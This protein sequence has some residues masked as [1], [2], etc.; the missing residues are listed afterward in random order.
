[1]LGELVL[2][3][4]LHVKNLGIIEDI[5]WNPDSG[6]SVIT[7]ETGAGKS[8]IIDAVEL[9]LYGSISPE[10]IRHGCSS[11]QIEGVFNIAVPGRYAD[12][13]EFLNE[14]V[15]T[16]E[17]D[18]LIIS[19]E[20][21][22]GK[23]AQIRINNH[24]VTRTF[25][26]QVG[27]WLI[28]IHG[29]SQHLSLLDSTAHIEFLDDFC[30]LSALKSSY[31]AQIVNMRALENK[32]ASLRSSEQETLRQQD[33]LK[34]QIEEIRQAEL[35]EGEDAEL[36]REKRIISQAVRLKEQA[37]QIYQTLAQSDGTGYSP[38]VVA[39]LHQ[40]VQSLRKL[41]ELDPELKPQ[42]EYLEKA[43][44]GIDESARDIYAYAEKLDFDPHRLEEIENRL[45][46]IRNLKRKF[47]TSIEQIAAF[48]AKSQQELAMLDR[49]QERG[50]EL[51]DSLA[52]SRNAAGQMAGQ[53]SAARQAA[54]IDL[55]QRVKKELNDLEMGHMDF[56][57]GISWTPSPDG[58]P[59][60]DN[61][62]LAFSTKGIDQVEFL[63]STN[64][65]EPLLPLA[66]IASTG[67]L[68]RFTL[69][70]KSALAAADRIPVLIF[71][72]IDIGVGGRSGEI[73]GKKLWTL[74]R[75]H[76]VICVTHLP[77]IAAFADSHF[78]VRKQTTG[79][80]TVSSLESL[81]NNGRMKETAL[82]LAGPSYSTAAQNNA[83]E[84]LKKA[85]L[86]KDKAGHYE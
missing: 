69:A 18:S 12:L 17:D 55:A 65:G 70:L 80:R 53:L 24:T 77:Q 23:P 82:M 38:S 20:I 22:T 48:Q 3:Q 63:V 71:D 42:L 11:A 44:F 75:H 7:G 46:L 29:Q 67:E 52:A 16:A 19:C 36:E 45:E 34:Y 28:D 84:L 37:V 4:E 47:G 14:K 56:R 61:Q 73:V 27:R 25:L 13:R 51:K 68:S 78:L 9:L 74:S 30:G 43:Y 79:D 2:L 6:F 60:K 21:K 49:S 64:P 32:I 41:S 35:H 40:A 86:W 26:R 72:E 62:L 8:L 50:I 59:G 85:S 66:R 15:I 54:A 81:D 83:R 58:L 1:L 5:C 76:Q 39:G 31:S 57:V 33:F 10:V